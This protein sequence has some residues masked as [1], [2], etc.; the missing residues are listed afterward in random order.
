MRSGT[1]TP[2][3]K[4]KR[5]TGGASRTAPFA[6]SLRDSKSPTRDRP[7]RLAS[8]QRSSRNDR[9][10]S[11]LC[12]PYRR[13]STP[14]TDEAIASFYER[15]KGEPLVLDKW[16]RMQAM[17]SAPNAFERVV[18]LSRASRAFGVS[19]TRTA[20]ARCSTRSPPE[21]PLGFHR[22]DGAAY[23]FIADRVLE[24]DAINPQVASRVSYLASISGS[25]TSPTGSALMSAELERI[26]SK[27]AISKDVREIVERALQ[28]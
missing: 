22:A 15:W 10:R 16:F 5:S 6:I 11:G 25:A 14:E 9:L 23:R 17:S 21:I 4:S 8:S 13:S 28:G 2:S 3:T 26:A 20:P 1:L 24:L 19:P 18:E 7:W 27:P 12:V